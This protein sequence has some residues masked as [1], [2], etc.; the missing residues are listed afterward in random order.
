MTDKDTPSEYVKGY[1]QGLKVAREEAKELEKTLTFYASI[2][3]WDVV[4]GS[5][6]DMIDKGIPPKPMK[7]LDCGKRAREALNKRSKEHE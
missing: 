5:C 3:N 2:D 6:H 1:E 4:K 7:V